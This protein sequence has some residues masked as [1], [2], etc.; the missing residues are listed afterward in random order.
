[1]R[2]HCRGTGNPP[3]RQWS[4]LASL[5]LVA[6]CSAPEARWW[7]GNL[8]THS[9]WSDGDDYPEMIVSWYRDNGY[10]FVA[11]SDHDILAEGEKW[12][13]IS[14]IPAGEAVHRRY[15]DAF[16]SDWVVE[17]VED[18]DTLVRLK[19][20]EEYRTLFDRDGEFLTIQAEEISDRF[21]QKPIHVN[22]TNIETVI[23][24]QGG[25]SVLD[26]M[27]NNIDAVLEQRRATGRPIMPHLVHPN[28]KWAVTAED[29]AALEGERFFE[30]YNGHPL[31]NN[32]GDSLRPG[33]EV[34]WDLILTSRLKAGK[35]IMY[36]LA[37][38]DAHNYR[39]DGPS[40][41]NPGRGWVVVRA[42]RLTADEIVA[43]LEAGDFYS[44]TG[45][46]L[47]D[48]AWD[49]RTLTV[50]IEPETDVRYE[51]I[52]I[53]PRSGSG[54][55]DDLILERVFGVRASYSLTRDE[56]YV[57]AKIVSTKAKANPVTPGQVEVAW[58]QP[59]VART[60]VGR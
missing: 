56:L 59:V 55:S 41:A 35:D 31:V 16:G 23:Q 14:D 15:V 13:N 29:L 17:R 60:E 1:M 47:R 7:K 58:T 46:E 39:G 34:M 42:P 3:I 4:I 38:D 21:E 53:G 45:V 6:A 51:I 28:Y 20:F 19:T 22:A 25:T 18:G 57:R 50:E 33:T 40:M 43:A 48:V 9:Y 12:I 54:G 8:H 27:Q 5:L 30:V 36:G 2:R 37:V 26:V 52:F 32:E 49:G 11:L 24:P 44:S 10:S